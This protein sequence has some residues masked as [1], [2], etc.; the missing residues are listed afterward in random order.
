MPTPRTR[1]GQA[2]SRGHSLQGFVVASGN[3]FQGCRRLVRTVEL[4]KHV[5]Q[6][7]F[8]PAELNAG[9]TGGTAALPQFPNHFCVDD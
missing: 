4:A 2:Q 7:P 9:L 8:P 3:H 1:F 6:L 5:L